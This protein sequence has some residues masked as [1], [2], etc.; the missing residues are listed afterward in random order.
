MENENRL[1]LTGAGLSA[2]FGAPTASEMSDFLFN[3]HQIQNNAKLKK[4]LSECCDYEYAY[5]TVMEDSVFESTDQEI[6]STAIRK[7]YESLDNKL[8]GSVANYAQTYGDFFKKIIFRFSR[9]SPYNGSGYIFTLNQDLLIERNFSKYP[10]S[11]LSSITV[12]LVFS[13]IFGK[14]HGSALLQQDYVKIPEDFEFQRLQ[15]ENQLTNCVPLSYIKLHGSQDWLFEKEGKNLMV[16]GRRKQDTIS[17]IPLLDYYWKKF[18]QQLN[19]PNSKILI[20]GYSFND[21]HVN[22]ALKSAKKNGL[23]V[24][25][26]NRSPREKIIETLQKHHCQPDDIIT[27]YYSNILIDFFSTSHP[28]L[29]EEM[30]SFFKDPYF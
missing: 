6:F 11:S 10:D 9:V 12:P 25:V 17:S 30:K 21:K 3:N 24:I 8:L 16:I 18:E 27:S 20:I 15:Y 5:Q 4:L 1:L 13:K 22:E 26:V 7:A 29:R 23:K 14:E 28:D 19:I 2:N